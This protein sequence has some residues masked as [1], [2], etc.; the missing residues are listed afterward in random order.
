MTL[1]VMM[2]IYVPVAKKA[3]SISKPLTIYVKLIRCV[4]NG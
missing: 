4:V 1:L 2:P 3:K